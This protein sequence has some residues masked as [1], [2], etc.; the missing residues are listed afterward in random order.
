MIRGALNRFRRGLRK[1]RQG[2]VGG[3][4]SMC[5]RRI[6]LDTETLEQSE[7]RLISADRGV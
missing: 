3:L 7:E 2:V 6:K 1:T 5:G 4:R